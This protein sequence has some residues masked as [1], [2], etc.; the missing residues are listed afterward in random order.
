MKSLLLIM[1]LSMASCSASQVEIVPQPVDN[2]SVVKEYDVYPTFKGFELVV[3]LPALKSIPI[4][5]FLFGEIINIRAGTN[6]D[7]LV[8]IMGPK[9][10]SNVPMGAPMDSPPKRVDRAKARW[11]QYR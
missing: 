5:G 6:Q 8:P 3:G 2:N 9:N 1:A 11:S 10:P 7:V 4:I